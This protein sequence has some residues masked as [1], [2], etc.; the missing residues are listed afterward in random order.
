[1]AV[2]TTYDRP[3]APARAPAAARRGRR[4]PTAWIFAGPAAVLFV[5]FFAYPLGASLLQ[6]FTTEDA[7]ATRWVGLDQYR[8]MIDDPAF[9]ESLFNTGVILVVQ[10]PVMIGLALVLAV[11]LNQSWLRFRGTWRAI[12]FLPAVTTLVAYAVVFQVLLKTDGGLVNQILGAV[13]IGQVD[14]LNNPTW[15]RVSLIASLTWRWTGYNA[16]ILL[17]GLQ[18]IGKEQYEAAAIDGATTFSTYTR[19]I[20]PQLR[21]VVLFCVI[22]ST[23]GTLQLFD[24][25]YVL[26]RGGPDDATL[27]PVVYLYKVGF[28]QLDFGYAA[29][30]AWVVVALIA[31]ISALQYIAFGRERRR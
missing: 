22:T 12:Y 24:E 15:A 30:I 23:I 27:T 19:V 1:M 28:Q 2:H 13:G 25:N 21:P 5:L 16:V 17:A 9:L 6:S 18:S 14:W 31:A 20:L 8:R 7:G 11:L 29:A 4:R 3:V 10:V 26:T